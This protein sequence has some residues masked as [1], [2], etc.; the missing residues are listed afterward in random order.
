MPYKCNLCSNKTK[1][2]KLNNGV[3]RFYSINIVDENEDENAEE[4]IEM[5]YDDYEAEESEIICY[6]CG[7]ND[8]DYV[9]TEEWERW[10]GPIIETKK[11]KK[12][13]WA[14][15]HTRIIKE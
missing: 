14:Q 5:D 7:S 9:N 3:C 8:V 10:K 6:E 4:S 15:R 11:Q 13:T 1:F 12:E 2:K